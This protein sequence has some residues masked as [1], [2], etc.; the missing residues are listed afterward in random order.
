[1]HL[2]TH[3]EYTNYGPDRATTLA[4]PKITPAMIRA[5]KEFYRKW[6]EGVDCNG[7]YMANSL[8]VDKL[9][10]GLFSVLHKGV[11]VMR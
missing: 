5:G 10:L 11:G 1:M 3:P 4:M 6:E 2:T 8:N 7:G 9:V